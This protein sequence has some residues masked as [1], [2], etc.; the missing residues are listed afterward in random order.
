MAGARSF[1]CPSCGAFL[2]FQPDTQ[3]LK[4]PF[5][6]LVLGP[7]AL[8]QM[9]Q[10]AAGPEAQEA[11][12]PAAGSG[13]TGYHCASCGAEIVTGETT[14]ATRCYFCHNPVVLDD[15]L[16]AEFRP[17][18]V[19]PFSVTRQ[20]ALDSFRGFLKKHRFVDRSFFRDEEMLQGVYYPYWLGDIEADVSFSGQG[21]RESRSRHGNYITIQTYYYD[22]RREGR[23]RYLNIIR[24][25]LKASERKLSD[26][27]HPYALEKMEPFTPACLSGF[28]AEMRDMTADDVK[29][30]MQ[31]EAER[32]ADGAIRA[33]HSFN[34]L[35]GKS[36][37]RTAQQ[38][39]RYCLLPAWVLTLPKGG[40]TYYYLIN[41]S[42]GSVCGR[43]PVDRKKLFLTCAVI[44]SAVAGLLCLGGAFLW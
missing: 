35:T 11:E 9:Q 19:L 6:S 39:M 2:E 37:F 20:Q 30:D 23:A 12:A 8:M 7:E 33:N 24:S 41:G 28:Q 15:R 32:W 44:G 26:G 42:T 5:C 31:Q 3:K 10:Q 22:V 25:A 13:L 29:T 27:I 36:V 16:S 34:S 21:T 38:R 18:A 1:K 40:K 4:C 14:A 17:D 43:I